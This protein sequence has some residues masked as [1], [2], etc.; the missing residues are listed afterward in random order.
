MTLYSHERMN[1]LDSDRLGSVALQRGVHP[2]ALF[3]PWGA[4]RHAEETRP[5]P[6]GQ[7]RAEA[8]RKAQGVNLQDALGADAN[9]LLPKR[10]ATPSPLSARA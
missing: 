5:G 2:G 8:R 9:A 6:E 7:A 1:P 10:P 4:P 3:D